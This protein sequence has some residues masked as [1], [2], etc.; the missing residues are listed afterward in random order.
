VTASES[1]TAAYVSALVEPG[2]RAALEESAREHDRSLSG[3]LRTALREYLGQP[4]R[5]ELVT[6][7]RALGE[8]RR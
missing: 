7:R 6:S 1:Q 8:V 3:E 2:L 4:E 5:V